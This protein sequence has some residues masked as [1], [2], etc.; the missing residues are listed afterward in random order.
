MNSIVRNT[1]LLFCVATV[2]ACSSSGPGKDAPGE[3]GTL[4]V[5]LSTVANGNTYVLTNAS[6]A[7]TGSTC[8]GPETT[9]FS[10]DDAGARELSTTLAAGQYTATLTT[11]YYYYPNECWTLDRVDAFGNLQPVTATLVSSPEQAFTIENGTTT[12]VTYT[13]ETDGVIVKVG[14]GALNVAIAVNQAAAAC[15]PLGTDCS[16]GNWCPPATLTGQDLACMAAGSVRVGEPCAAVSDCVANASCFDLGAGPVCTALCAATNLGAPCAS[17]GTC[18]A[19]DGG[20]DYGICV[21]S[22]SDA[23]DAGPAPSSEAGGP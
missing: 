2:G 22:A 11:C 9:L 3:I 19:T 15:T 18:D 10:G 7:I 21:P 14:S 1:T 20:L 6:I 13:F 12:T 23:G 5:P 17:G 8:C 16:V 4:S